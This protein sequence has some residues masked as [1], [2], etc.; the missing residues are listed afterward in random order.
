MPRRKPKPTP[1]HSGPRQPAV[2]PERMIAADVAIFL[3]RAGEEEFTE[4][5]I[6]EFTRQGAP[7]NED[8]SINI[9][10]FTAWLV[11]TREAG[12]RGR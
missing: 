10:R 11:R 4:D 6:C 3:T 8:G 7:C 9:V 12:W 2:N 5:D 1:N